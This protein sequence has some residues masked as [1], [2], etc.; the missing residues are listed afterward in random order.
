M[1]TQ[2]KKFE[3]PSTSQY[4]VDSIGR[5][6]QTGKLRTGDKLPGE[7]ELAER[8][9]VSRSSVREGL[10]ILAAYGVLEIRHGQ[11]TFVCDGF[12]ESLAKVLPFVPIKEN[13]EPMLATR[14]ILETGAIRLIYN[15]ISDETCDELEQL[16]LKISPDYSLDAI[17]SADRD[18]H[19]VLMETTHNPLLLRIYEMINTILDYLMDSL[20]SNPEVRE[21]ARE[22]HLQIVKALREKDEMKSVLAMEEHLSNVEAFARTYLISAP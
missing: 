13:L 1:T 3:K 2:F 10:S 21:K 19:R 16:S 12:V 8:L 11:G 17:I 4:V 18:F 5:E 15:K 9:G 14:R 22:S 6:I 7:L 20:M